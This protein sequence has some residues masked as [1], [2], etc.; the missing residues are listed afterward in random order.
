[1]GLGY[2]GKYLLSEVAREQGTKVVLT[3]EGS[4]EHFAGYQ[5]LT[6]DAIC[7]PDPAWPSNASTEDEKDRSV[8][9]TRRNA[10][11]TAL[12]GTNDEESIAS[13]GSRV[14]NQIP[15][16]K[17]FGGLDVDVFSAWAS[18]YGDCNS[19]DN[20]SNS[21]DGRARDKINTKWHPLHS[22]LY[23]YQKA[24]LS[25]I[26]LTNLGD[27]TEMAH[28]LEARTPF[29]DHHLT[30]YVNGIPPS[31]KIKWDSK[32]KTFTEKWVL[33]EAMKPFI[34]EEMYKRIKH[35]SGCDLVRPCGPVF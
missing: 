5:P 14:L 34:T 32:T 31:L 15:S 9:A 17:T 23:L 27:R 16:A 12:I 13:R 11:F 33:R 4:D 28:S 19:I 1:M 7:E 22:A 10:S 20:L 26:L 18:C 30:E 29:L 25:G 6:L 8:E 35:V 2:I 3:G 24:L 21:L